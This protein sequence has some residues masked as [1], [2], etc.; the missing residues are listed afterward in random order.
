MSRHSLGR[1]QVCDRH[2]R[3]KEDGRAD[4]HDVGVQDLFEQ[5]VKALRPGNDDDN[6][7]RQNCHQRK[8]RNE[9]IGGHGST[10]PRPWAFFTACHI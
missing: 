10:I 6:E 7:S 4:H 2:D 1:D 3:Q 9:D 5:F 8:D